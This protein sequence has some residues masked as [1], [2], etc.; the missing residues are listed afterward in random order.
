MRLSRQT[1]SPVNIFGC[2]DKL[3]IRLP[4]VGSRAVPRRTIPDAFALAIGTRIKNLREEA[5]FTIERLAYESDVGSKGHLSSIER[6][7]VRP[8]AHTL[9]TLADGLGIL[10][11]DVVNFP[12][13]GDRQRLFDLT[14]QLSPPRVKAL[15]RE[16]EGSLARYG[17]SKAADSAGPYRERARRAGP[18]KK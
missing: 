16:V 2:L 6:G 7:L 11:T 5:G 17:I 15:L 18:A 1:E 12:E 8:T 9:R 13:A 4:D 14:R 3:V 10:V